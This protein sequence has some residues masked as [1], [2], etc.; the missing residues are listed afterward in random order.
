MKTFFL[1]IAFVALA[2]GCSHKPSTSLTN[3]DMHEFT[4]V[5]MQ[6]TTNTVLGFTQSPTGDV[7][8]DVTGG[9]Y[10]LHHASNGWVIVSSTTTQR[11][12]PK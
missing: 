4:S 9:T 11:V 3:S 5:V 10:V 12:F 6:Q 7:T 8:V 2:L 1:S